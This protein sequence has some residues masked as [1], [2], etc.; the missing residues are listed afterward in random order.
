LRYQYVGV[1]LVGGA[2][3]WSVNLR[4]SPSL[5]V[6]V[7]VFANEIDAAEA[8]DAAVFLHY[9]DPTKKALWSGWNVAGGPPGAGHVALSGVKRPRAADN[10][11]NGDDS[12]AAPAS[13]YASSSAFATASTSAATATWPTWP[14]WASAS[15]ST[16]TAVAPRPRKKKRV[17]THSKNL[18]S[19]VGTC[20]DRAKKLSQYVGVRWESWHVK[21]VATHEGGESGVRSLVRFIV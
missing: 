3:P 18:P 20:G 12:A 8:Y 11:T 10:S 6:H 4:V 21:G 2:C 14:T 19:R 1:T 15:A 17:A 16:A 9:P 7:G 13:A 5:N